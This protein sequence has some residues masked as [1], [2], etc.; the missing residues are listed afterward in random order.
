MG[1]HGYVYAHHGYAY[2]RGHVMGRDRLHVCDCDHGHHHPYGHVN[3][4]RVHD[5]GRLHA[6][7]RD[8]GCVNG[9]ARGR[10]HVHVHRRVRDRGRL[11]ADGRDHGH[12]NGHVRVR[13]NDCAGVGA[14]VHVHGCVH[15]HCSTASYFW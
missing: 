5:R 9:H 14:D 6:D 1:Q 3:G 13:A 12:A 4:R 10:R 11:R 15:P 7:G 8:R 2:V